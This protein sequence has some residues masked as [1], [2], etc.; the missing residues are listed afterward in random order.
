MKEL[1]I[2]KFFKE[3][4]NIKLNFNEEI[5]NQ[6]FKYN[7]EEQDLN[8][9]FE[10]LSNKD[11]IDN[12][13]EAVYNYDNYVSNSITQYLLEIGEYKLL[14]ATDEYELF[15]KYNDGD[16]TIAKKIFECNLRLVVSVAK[17]YFGR[18]MDLLDLIQ[19]GNIGLLKAIKK[20]D[21]TK[22]FKFSTYATWWIRQ[23]I[24]RSM[25]NQA[26]LVRL[27]VH[28]F[29][30]IKK[31]QIIEKKL[32]VELG[33]YPTY[34]DLAVEMNVSIEKI[35]EYKNDCE[36]I[37]PMEMKIGEEED[38]EL[39]H[40]IVDDG[41]QVENEVLN[42]L[43][44]NDFK[45]LLE[46]C[47]TPKE[48]YILTKLFGLDNGCTHTL[49]SVGNEFNVTRERIRQ[50]KDKALRKLKSYIKFHKIYSKEELSELT[51]TFVDLEEIQYVKKFDL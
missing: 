41:V 33:R 30:Q 23:N 24:L 2:I 27:P 13:N 3:K 44:E 46:K 32:T 34:E 48:K 21:I 9:L 49:E 17:K 16:T 12:E 26:N 11:S 35:I 18:G 42:N 40:F 43:N 45:K 4:Y 25:A 15:T 31:M 36:P 10:F 29:E 19:E 6:I 28:R 38:S 37:L 20:F 7:I 39:G 47:L 50:I 22:G 1:E 8:N 14:S 51:G 5:N